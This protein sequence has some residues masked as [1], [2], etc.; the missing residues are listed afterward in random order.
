MKENRDKHTQMKMKRKSRKYDK[1]TYSNT[2]HSQLTLILL[3][4]KIW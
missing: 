4:W 3:T 2:T 1:V